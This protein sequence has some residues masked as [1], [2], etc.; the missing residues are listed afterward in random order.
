MRIPQL[1]SSPLRTC[2]ASEQLEREVYGLFGIPVD[3]A[4][5]QTVVCL[6]EKAAAAGAPFL[7]VDGESQFF[8]YEPI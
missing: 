5:I 4:D 7:I 8:S 2:S 1:S 3:V 6:I